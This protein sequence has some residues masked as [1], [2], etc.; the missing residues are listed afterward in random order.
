MEKALLYELENRIPEL[1][2]TPNASGDFVYPSSYHVFP[3]NIPEGASKP[4]LVYARIN[5][6]KVKTLKGYTGNESLS[7]MLSV[8]AVKNGDMM[9]IRDKVEALLISFSKTPIGEENIFVEDVTINNITETWENE[10][11]VNR[12]IIDFTIYY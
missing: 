1:A 4:L 5:T 6:S 7:Y 3:A 10:L 11:K 9:K 8:M 2:P 12:G